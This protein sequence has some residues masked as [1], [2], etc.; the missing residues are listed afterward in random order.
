MKNIRVF[1]DLGSVAPAVWLSGLLAILL[2]VWAVGQ[3][4]KQSL[5]A[6]PTATVNHDVKIF[7]GEHRLFANIGPSTSLCWPLRLQRKFYRY[8][9]KVGKEC[10]LEIVNFSHSGGQ[11]R[12][13]GWINCHPSSTD[14]NKW[15]AQ[16]TDLY[17]KTV[18]SLIQKNPQTPVIVI[19]ML[20]TG[21]AC[22][23]F[24]CNPGPNAIQGPDDTVHIDMATSF[25]RA[26]LMAALDDGAAM[27]FLSPKKYWRALDL[28]KELNRNEERYAL[29]KVAAEQVAGLVYVKGVWED[30]AE[31]KEIAL[32]DDGHHP[33]QLGD[34]IIASK[35]FQAML[36]H[37][38]LAVPSWDQQEVDAVRKAI[39]SDPSL[40][41]ESLGENPFDVDDN[42]DGWLSAEECAAHKVGRDENGTFKTHRYITPWKPE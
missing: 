2:T 38:G 4:A 12:M 10:P 30:T 7:N 25:L 15:E 34:E 33:T 9:G 31:D 22:D 40:R 27:Y 3:S 23:G 29:T 26:H 41:E 16:R 20:N 39:Q 36:V 11:Y 21:L 1:K 6:S 18:L 37:D 24:S 42:R 17:K 35:F 28:P 32:V 19:A 5:A 14:P 13:P 8:T